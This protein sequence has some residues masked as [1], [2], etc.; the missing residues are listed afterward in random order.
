MILQRLAVRHFKGIEAADYRQLAPTLNLF[1]GANESGKSTLVE[2]LHFALFEQAKGS[3]Q[4]K[5]ALQS[6]GHDAAPEVEVSFTDAQGEEWHVFKRFL[7]NPKTVVDVGSRHFEGEQAEAQL[8][9]A[10]GTQKGNRSGVKPS[11][12]GIWPLLWVR[13][14]QAGTPTKDALNPSARSTLT[15]TLA[16]AT[17]AVAAGERGLAILAEATRDARTYYTPT[18]KETGPLKLARADAEAAQRQLL[19]LQE[20]HTKAQGLAAQIEE[21][22]DHLDQPGRWRPV[23]G[24]RRDHALVIHPAGDFHFP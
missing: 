17:G 11:E 18:G 10:F 24:R 23:L 6:W 13:Q 14:G 15:T 3:A 1:Y 16:E 20:R 21:A 4:H 12:M 7:R 19:D 2:A 8:R 9:S 5:K 22:R